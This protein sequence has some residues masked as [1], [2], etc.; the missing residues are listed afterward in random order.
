MVI[1]SKC[2]IVFNVYRCSVDTNQMAK[3]KRVYNIYITPK[4]LDDYTQTHQH[5]HTY[6]YAREFEFKNLMMGGNIILQKI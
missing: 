5:T 6:I 2:G 1:H 3:P 4:H